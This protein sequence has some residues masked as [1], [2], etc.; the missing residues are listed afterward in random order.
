M[1]K[2]L[3]AVTAASILFV[4]VQPSPAVASSKVVSSGWCTNYHSLWN[5]EMSRSGSRVTSVLTVYP[6]NPRAKW[7]ANWSYSTTASD[8]NLSYTSD[9]NGVL[10]A[11]HRVSS[12][13]FTQ[14]IVTVN[15]ENLIFC[16]AGGFI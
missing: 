16:T 8:Y 13:R 3:L 2:K 14:M 11:T 4:S 15:Y 6:A 12:S 5:L 7:G 1:F 10:K 9:R